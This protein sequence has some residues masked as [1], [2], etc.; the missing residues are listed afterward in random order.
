MVVQ[1]NPSGTVLFNP[2]GSVAMDADCCCHTYDC[3]YCTITL[4]PDEWVIDL[5]AGGF[6]NGACGQCDQLKGEYVASGKWG[7]CWWYYYVEDFLGCTNCDAWVHIK[8]EQAPL[9]YPYWRYRATAQM[10]SVG[11]PIWTQW[12]SNTFDESDCLS[13]NVLDGN[14][15][16]VLTQDATLDT[17]GF[18]DDPGNMPATI[19]AWPN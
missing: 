6:T 9:G 5:G 2:S 11:A 12:I 16:V 18:C 3:I 1:F 4:S 7:A 13:S 19:Y 14:G 17:T 15:K 8:I 10:G